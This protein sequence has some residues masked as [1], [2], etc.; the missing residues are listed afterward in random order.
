MTIP[1]PLKKHLK[2]ICFL[3]GSALCAYGLMLIADDS[4][5]LLLA[6]V[7]NYIAYALQVELKNEGFI[8]R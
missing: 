4:R 3:L 5:L 2:I 8:R 1:E 6:P 7:I